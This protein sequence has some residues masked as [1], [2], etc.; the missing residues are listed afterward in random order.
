MTRLYVSKGFY[1]EKYLNDTVEYIAGV[2]TSDGAI[3]W[4]DGGSLDPK[5]SHDKTERE[6]YSFLRLQ[7]NESLE[8]LHSK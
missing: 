2:Q 5:L 4:Y 1:P 7:R 3:P 6:V 8:R